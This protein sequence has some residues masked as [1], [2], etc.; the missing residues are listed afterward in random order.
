[1]ITVKPLNNKV[2]AAGKWIAQIGLPAAATLYFA[3]SQV[4][5]LPNATEVVGTITSFD[6]FI[7]VLLG[8]STA[9]YNASDAKYDGTITVVQD[10]DEKKTFSLNLPGDPENLDQQKQVV[11]KVVSS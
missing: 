10:S 1:M 11:F 3:L 2:Y 9:S 8:L 7:G 6:A 4:W 5:G